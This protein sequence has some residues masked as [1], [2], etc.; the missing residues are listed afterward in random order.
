MRCHE[1]EPARPGAAAAGVTLVTSLVSAGIGT[2]DAASSTSYSKRVCAHAATGL[3]RLRRARPHRWQPQA[4]RDHDLGRPTATAPAQLKTA[5]GL[6]GRN[7]TTPVAIVDAYANPN[8]QTDLAA[9]RTQFGLTAT[10]SPRYNQ[11]G[12]SIT[13]VAGNIGWG[14]EEM[15]DLE[16]VSAICP[17]CPILYVGA[18]SASFNDLAAAVNT[19]AAKGAKVISNSYGGNEFSTETSLTVVVQPPG[20]RRSPQLR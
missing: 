20:R 9:Y 14:Q 8:A 17:A 3:R 2:A 4:A 7:G 11:T 18:N 19:A 16:M 6:T 15:L 12:G 1:A 10:P 13:T 5:Y